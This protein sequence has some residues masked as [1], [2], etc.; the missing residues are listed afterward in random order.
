MRS[1]LFQ[2][3]SCRTPADLPRGALF[4]TGGRAVLRGHGAVREA[5]SARCPTR[6]W[7]SSPTRWAWSRSCP[8]WRRWAPGAAD[9]HLPN[10]LLRGCWAANMYCLF[11]AMGRLRL[12]D[13]ILLNDSTPLIMPL[14]ERFWLGSRC[15]AGVGA[16]RRG[17]RRHR[18]GASRAWTSSSPRRRW[19]WQ[20]PY[21]RDGPG[22]RA[23]LTATEPPTRIV[24]S[25]ATIST[26][27]AVR[28]RSPGRRRRR[29]C[30]GAAA[31]GVLATWPDVADTR[32][33]PGAGGPG[34]ALH[35]YVVVPQ[36]A[37]W[38]L[39]APRPTPLRRGRR[40]GRARAPWPYAAGA[41]LDCLAGRC[42]SS[43]GKGSCG[44]RPPALRPGARDRRVRSMSIW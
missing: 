35:L 14:V 11:Y 37:H 3:T 25:F 22:G 28:R 2:P 39:L 24:F 26:D 30:G 41:R 43:H 27:S 36:A 16:H 42:G 23:P 18:A 40:P 29:R 32:V 33:R 6:R 21:R 34:R 9:E 4:M 10:H 17:L 44:R 7:C 13:A 31:M 12:A 15:H 1:M 38:L 8:G 20:R 5:A 19:R